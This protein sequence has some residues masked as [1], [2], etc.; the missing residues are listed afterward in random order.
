[1][2]ALSPG[3]VA[4]EISLP[5]LNGAGKISL[6]E[7]RRQGLVIAAFFKI[8]CPVC[9]FAFPYLERIYRAYAD[10]KVSFI[11]VSQNE[12]EDSRS[13]AGQY[14]VT[15]PIAL[16]D[17]RKYP[18]S[19]A[20]GLTTVPSIFLI[21]PEGKIEMTS[22]GWDKKDIEELNRRVAKASSMAPVPV[23]KPGEQ[24]PDFKAG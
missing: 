21:S 8:S 24:V 19:N 10:G 2:A 17:T 6:S 12:A 14:K 7:R 18:A 15:F 4:P 20:Y 11:G 13:F 3:S 9:Q 16:D 1:M 22:V 23:F 5:S